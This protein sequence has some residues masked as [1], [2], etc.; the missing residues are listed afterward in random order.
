[1]LHQLHRRDDNPFLVDFAKSAHTGRCATADINMVGQA[2]NIA[3]QFSAMINRRNQGN[4]IEMHAA[5]IGIIG[6]NG[7][8]RPQL[9]RAIGGQHIGHR[10]PQRPQMIGLG[11]RLRH[12]LHPVIEKR[13]R[14]VSA[15]LDIGRVGAATQRNR[16]LFGRFQQSI[17]DHFKFDWIK[18]RCRCC[19]RHVSYKNG[20]KLDC[21]SVPQV[22]L[23]VKQANLSLVSLQI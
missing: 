23:C 14:K 2:G 6:K 17:A 19:H 15:R 12:R 13:T 9:F 1:M 11:K 16:H 18:G 8:A 5:Q 3:D 22:R 7:V 21:F 10:T 20:E 4:V